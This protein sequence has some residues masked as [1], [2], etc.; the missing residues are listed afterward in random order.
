[1][2][3]IAV[4]Y[5]QE[6]QTAFLTVLQDSMCSACHSGEGCAAC[7]K[8]V[9]RSKADNSVGAVIGDR[10]EIE[11]ADST[12]LWYS[13]CVFIFPLLSAAIGYLLAYL[14]LLNGW[15]TV[16]ICAAFFALSFLILRLTLN[17]KAA[18]RNDVKIVRILERQYEEGK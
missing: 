8:K 11:T 5:K 13:V 1:M 6:G 17:R 10:V 3:Q 2:K 16:L 7:R 15:W 14:L 9:I 12:I 18:S 4:V